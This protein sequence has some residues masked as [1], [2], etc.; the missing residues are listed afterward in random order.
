MQIKEIHAA[1]IITKSHLPDADYVINPYAG[2]THKCIYCYARFMKR[3]TGH[4]ENW[5]EFIDVK[6]NAPDLNPPDTTKYRGKSIFMSSVTDPY[7]PLEKKYE[8]TRKILEK[9]IPLQPDLGILTKSDLVLRDI[10]LLRQFK[11]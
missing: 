8:L 4:N 1:S 2:C 5:G 6:V 7:L 9:L 11:L 10:D 3:F